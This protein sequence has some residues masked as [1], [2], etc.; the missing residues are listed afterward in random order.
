MQQT[1]FFKPHKLTSALVSMA[2]TFDAFSTFFFGILF[3]VIAGLSDPI[4]DNDEGKRMLV[5]LG[6]LV[7]LLTFIYF[8]VCF[9]S[10]TYWIKGKRFW[11]YVILFLG[12]SNV[13]GYS[14]FFAVSR[15]EFS[16]FIYLF[17]GSLIMN[18]PLIAL[19]IYNEIKS[20]SNI[21]ESNAHRL[22]AVSR[23]GR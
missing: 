19:I 22:T 4:S 20:K 13:A 14:Y 21:K 7:L 8:I 16:F 18:L 17:Y 1:I 3:F 12:L 9:T 15:S 5:R 23:D 10:L 6:V 11:S 2:M